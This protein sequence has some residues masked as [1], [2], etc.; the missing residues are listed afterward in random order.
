VFILFDKIIL[1]SGCNALSTDS[2]F[3]DMFYL[4][5]NLENT[6]I[7]MVQK[8]YFTEKYFPSVITGDIVN[9]ENILIYLFFYA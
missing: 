2:K 4:V 7:R 1:G 3:L 6:T 5:N 9:Y 8:L